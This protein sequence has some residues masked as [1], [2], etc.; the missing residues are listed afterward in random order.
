MLPVGGTEESY[1]GTGDTELTSA[2]YHG[3]SWGAA[4]LWPVWGGGGAGERGD[5]LEEAAPDPFL[6]GEKD[7]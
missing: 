2:W 7:I 5:L 6:K 1:R 3:K 4:G